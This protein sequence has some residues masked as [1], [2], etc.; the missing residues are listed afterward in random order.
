MTIGATMAEV[1]MARAKVTMADEI[2]QDIANHIS[3]INTT[4]FAKVGNGKS[5]RGNT[6]LNAWGYTGPGFGARRDS[7][8]VTQQPQTI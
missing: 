8:S 7:Q 3:H 6:L 4:L 2:A 5:S 1:G